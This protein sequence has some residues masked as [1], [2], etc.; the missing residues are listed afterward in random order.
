VGR[1]IELRKVR[2]S[3]CRLSSEFKR[4]ESG[5]AQRKRRL[6]PWE[7]LTRPKKLFVAFCCICSVFFVMVGVVVAMNLYVDTKVPVGM[8]SFQD[9]TKTGDGTPEKSANRRAKSE[10][11]SVGMMLLSTVGTVAGGG[12]I[13]GYEGEPVFVSACG[14]E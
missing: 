13:E 11:R 7:T 8:S 12:T 4:T 14:I 10:R 3:G 1:A 6:R 9:L 5:R 2:R